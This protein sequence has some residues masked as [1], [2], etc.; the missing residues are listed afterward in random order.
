MDAWLPK[1]LRTF[2]AIDLTSRRQTGNGAPTAVSEAQVDAMFSS[3]GFDVTWYHD[4]TV[5]LSAT[6]GGVEVEAS[7]DIVMRAAPKGKFRFVDK[8]R[9]SVGVLGS[10]GFRD[11]SLV[12]RNRFRVFFETF[13]TVIDTLS[14][15]AIDIRID[16]ACA[17][18]VQIDDV[19][20]D[21]L[22]L[23]VA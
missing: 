9:L 16:N 7:Q 13:E 8:G 15:P 1:P 10:G 17:N 18:G 5:K 11:S 12:A 23:A 4:P 19:V 2:M 3:V 21:C 22:G 14:A 20:L 6:S